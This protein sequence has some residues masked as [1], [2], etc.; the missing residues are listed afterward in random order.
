MQAIAW[1]DPRC[2]ALSTGCRSSGA[3]FGWRDFANH[4]RLALPVVASASRGEGSDEFQT[5]AEEFEVG[6]HDDL[7]WGCGGDRGIGVEG[8]C[9]K[10]NARPS[11]CVPIGNARSP[12]AA[13][14]PGFVARGVEQVSWPGW[15]FRP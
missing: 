10:E 2:A 12:D 6:E 11:R 1:W 13:M 4:G 3:V 14:H 15:P 8:R 5:E 7:L 9:L